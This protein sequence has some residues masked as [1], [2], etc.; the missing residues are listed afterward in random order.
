MKMRYKSKRVI[1]KKLF[2][3]PS[4]AIGTKLGEK[5]PDEHIEKCFIDI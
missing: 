2:G 5:L 1:Y 3:I 4:L